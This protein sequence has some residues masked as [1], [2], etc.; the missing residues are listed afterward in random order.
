MKVADPN[1]LAVIVRLTGLSDPIG[2]SPVTRTLSVRQHPKRGSRHQQRAYHY[3]PPFHD[4][5][6]V[7]KESALRTQSGERASAERR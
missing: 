2:S 4:V 5:D 6:P 1:G 3:R 7:P